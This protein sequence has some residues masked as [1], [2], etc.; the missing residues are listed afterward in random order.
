MQTIYKDGFNKD[1][2]QRDVRSASAHWEVFILAH[3]PANSH[4]SSQEQY[5]SCPSASWSKLCSL[6]ESDLR[7]FST[8]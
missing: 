3:S 6:L 8:V 2:K 5:L 1:T 7:T 4:V